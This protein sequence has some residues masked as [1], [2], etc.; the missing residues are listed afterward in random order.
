M[1]GTT[2]NKRLL[3]LAA[4]IFLLTLT[5]LFALTSVT[6]AAETVGDFE[7]TGGASGTDYTY[8]DGVLTINTSAALTVK[9]THTDIPT[10]D[11]IVIASGVDA[12]I[13]LAGV[14]ID[15]S[16][17]DN[18]CALM[19]ANDSTGNVKITLA[20]GTTNI[21]KS[22]KSRA[23]LQ[24]N[25]SNGSL[26]ITGS[27]G[28]LIAVGGHSGSGIGSNSGG[29]CC[30]ITISGGVI[31]ATGGGSAA[32]IGTGGS[33]KK[34]TNITISGGSV[35]AQG[36]GCGAGIGGGYGGSCSDVLISGG[37]VTA[38]GSNG[39]AGIGGG[40]YCGSGTNIT[41][42]GGTVIAI[43]GSSGAGIGGG[44]NGE[45]IEASGRGTNITVSGGTVTAKS[46]TGAG[47]GGGEKGIGAD[48]TISGGSVKTASTDGNLIGG[49]K[50][51][52]AVAP[53]NGASEKVYLLVIKNPSGS[54]VYIDNT[55]YS[56]KNHTAA[57]STDTNLYVYVTGTTHTANVDGTDTVYN[58]HT[59]KFLA[60]PKAVDFSVTAFYDL[61][62]DGTEKTATVT[63][64]DGITGMG[65]ISVKYYDESGNEAV[66]VNVGT[67]TLK[68]DTAEG[69]SYEAIS[70]LSADYWTFTVESASPGASDFIFEEP[71]DLI[72]SGTAK[73]AVVTAADGIAGMGK[74]T[75]KY[76]DQDG[77][78]PVNPINVN[79]YTVKI[80]VEAGANYT[81]ANDLTCPIGPS[82]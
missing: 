1:I 81:A 52:D 20:D 40:D 19:I 36:G 3:F 60:V 13:T 24:K 29:V 30:N 68:V 49:G 11:T 7:I 80:D 32:G 67:Y 23:G 22:G 2:K 5:A 4:V 12:D 77:I 82:R 57:D 44:R 69:E 50:S 31:E 66:P 25:G 78:N 47:I 56:L 74:V 75:V 62:Y 18:V 53:V 43:G 70:S 6:A 55:A 28:K 9:N 35:T 41:V 79:S 73:S 10:T 61:V 17:D 8:A 39:G 46:G 48:I 33:W 42:S 15:V 51:C 21:L 72:Y 59:D 71:A 16:A 63:A 54:T 65:E 64:A 37:W 14:N 58:F 76:Y 45:G 34:C 27:T 38:K 26:E